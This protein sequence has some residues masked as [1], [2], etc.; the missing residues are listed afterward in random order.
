MTRIALRDIDTM[1][2]QAGELTMERGNLNV[3]RALANA[4]R[5]FTGWMLA[6]RAALTSPVLSARLREG[7]VLRVGYL[8]DSPYEIAQ[9]TFVAK[10]AACSMSGLQSSAPVRPRRRVCGDLPRSAAPRSG[11]RRSGWARPMFRRR[12]HQT[13]ITMENPK[14]RSSYE[15][16]TRSSYSMTA[17]TKSASPPHP[18]TTSSSRRTFRIEKRIPIPNRPQ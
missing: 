1:T 17:S 4:E 10:R 3:H 13:A 12:R 14:P 9:H 11:R 2:G 7:V 8:M 6:G 18:A 5:V 15:A 16:G